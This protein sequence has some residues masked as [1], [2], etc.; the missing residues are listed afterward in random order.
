MAHGA[1][2][3][4]PPGDG[5]S[6]RMALAAHAAGAWLPPAGLP[7]GMLSS[8]LPAR[9]LHTS[10]AVNEQAEGE[11]AKGA[12]GRKTSRYRGVSWDTR[13]AAW[14]A[15][16]WDRQT[17]CQ[18]HIGTYA[19]EEDAARAYDWAAVKMHGPECTK[20][21]FLSELI[22]ELPLTLRRLRHEMREGKT[23]RFF[24]VSWNKV[25]EAW[26]V[27]LW[28]PKAKRRQYIGTYVSEEDAARAYDCEAV[29][30]HGP[31]YT[32]R[33]F[34]GE[35]ISERPVSLGDEWR[36][37]KTSDYIGVSWHKD[38]SAWHARLWD[39]HTKRTQHIGY[40]DSE[41]DA[42]RAYDCALVE[43]RGPGFTKRNFP[44]EFISEPSAAQGRKR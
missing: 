26:H 18:Q 1:W 11:Q 6:P 32:E 8:W 36:E 28:D 33:N 13:D 2:S 23:S 21:N 10:A 7:M 37:R 27:Q 14:R 42:A 34:P 30:M 20:R 31:G 12:P 4:A 44:N 24:G 38:A 35:L 39:P 19:S 15:R 17:K 41:E 40:Y 9:P 22:S 25:R 5:C 43:L 29:K 3:V 16:L